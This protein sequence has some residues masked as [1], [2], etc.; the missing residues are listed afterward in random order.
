MVMS[1]LHLVKVNEAHQKVRGE[2]FKV[3]QW[4]CK[5]WNSLFFLSWKAL[6]VMV[7]I[8]PHWFIQL[9]KV[10]KIE[11]TSFLLNG[12]ISTPTL[13][14][15]QC[16]FIRLSDSRLIISKKYRFRISYFSLWYSAEPWSEQPLTSPR[17]I[18]KSYPFFV[19]N[20]KPEFISA[21]SL[22]QMPKRVSFVLT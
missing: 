11:R 3:F 18:R 2:G 1:S 16:H 12:S 17:R 13:Q 15:L 8:K 4:F 14:H 9:E 10:T 6:A 21:R 22:F 20:Y 19:W 5:S 7:T